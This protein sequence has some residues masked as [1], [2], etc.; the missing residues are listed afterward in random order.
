MIPFRYKT[1]AIFC[2]ITFLVPLSASLPKFQVVAPSNVH[3]IAE[4]VR[5]IILLAP[6]IKSL[7][8]M[9]L[10]PQIRWDAS[11]QWREQLL[12]TPYSQTLEINFY[13]PQPEN[14]TQLQASAVK[15]HSSEDEITVTVVAIA[16]S[17]IPS[18]LFGESR[19]RSGRYHIL[20]QT[21]YQPGLLEAIAVSRLKF[22]LQLEA[23]AGEETNLEQTMKSPLRVSVQMVAE[24]SIYSSKC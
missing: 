23:L 24:Y 5:Q 17:K 18:D 14:I 13:T 9:F 2:T 1:L 7:Q 20:T 8:F 10:F 11:W 3:I 6:E 15:R 19:S 12:G 22:K 4:A 21:D 16:P